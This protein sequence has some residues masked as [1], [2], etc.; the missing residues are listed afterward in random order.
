MH[1]VSCN[2]SVLDVLC[3]VVFVRRSKQNDK[4]LLDFGS[5]ARMTTKERR[6]GACKRTQAGRQAERSRMLS[7]TPRASFERGRTGE[8][9]GELRRS[10]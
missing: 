4:D 10:T 6:T 8:E 2:V 1:P 5:D 3:F 7:V 9:I